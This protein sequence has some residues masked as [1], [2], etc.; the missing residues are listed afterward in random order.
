MFHPMPCSSGLFHR[1]RPSG[2]ADK[3]SPDE[4]ASDLVRS[5]G[6]NPLCCGWSFRQ[7]SAMYCKLRA[8]LFAKMSCFR[9]WLVIFFGPRSK[10][11]YQ[12]WCLT[13]RHQPLRVVRD[14]QSE[15]V[16]G[17]NQM[18]DALH[19]RQDP[20]I[21]LQRLSRASVRQWT[22][23]HNPGR[24]RARRIDCMHAARF[25]VVSTEMTFDAEMASVVAV[26]QV[27]AYAKSSKHACLGKLGWPGK[28]DR[29]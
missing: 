9:S 20:Q 14:R 28:L 11:T 24:S 29:G 17:N 15:H 22:R 6:L 12:L 26:D 10:R 3:F 16:A 7:E 21:V 19:F 13:R 25:S 18:R 5:I 4:S 27:G 8:V 2:S 23:F 1:R